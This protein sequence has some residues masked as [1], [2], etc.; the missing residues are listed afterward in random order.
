MLVK[1]SLWLLLFFVSTA[2]DHK[3]KRYAIN[4]DLSPSDRWTQ[5]I[6]DH[7]DAIPAVASISRL[8]IPEVLQPLVW[9]LA[10]QLTY[11]FPVEYTEEL[12][13]IARESGLPLGEVVGLN[14]L[15]DITA[16][17]RRQ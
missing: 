2:A 3:P 14:I 4:L 5:V 10:S 9:W 8:Y 12:K 6:R 11:F 1:I 16:F 17:D 7:S 15:Y 13:G